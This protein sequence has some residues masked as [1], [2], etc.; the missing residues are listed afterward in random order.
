MSSSSKFLLEWLRLAEP[1]QS[2]VWLAVLMTFGFLLTLTFV[3]TLDSCSLA[4]VSGSR[5]NLLAN[6]LI[7]LGVM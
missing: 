2:K 4:Y 7:T 6:K 1:L 5:E 3:A